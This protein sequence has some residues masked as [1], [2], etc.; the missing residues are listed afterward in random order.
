[1]RGLRG[2]VVGLLPLYSLVPRIQA[3]G[4]VAI[5]DF[6]PGL[7][8]GAAALYLVLPE[9]G[10]APITRLLRIPAQR[11]TAVAAS[12]V[13]LLIVFST[14]VQGGGFTALG[15]TGLRL[16]SY[17]LI[18]AFL[19][20]Q[21]WSVRRTV[22]RLWLAVALAHASCAVFA[23]AWDWHGPLGMGLMQGS[24]RGQGFFSGEAAT[25]EGV[26]NRVN[27]YSAYLL[28]SLGAVP[29]SLKGRWTRGALLVCAVLFAGIV[30]AQTRMTLIALV[31]A[32]LGSLGWWR[33]CRPQ[34]AP[35]ETGRV[36]AGR[37]VLLL[38]LLLGVSGVWLAPT[39]SGM[40]IFSAATDRPLQWRIAGGVIAESPLWGV[41]DRRYLEA[42][43]RLF[44][45]RED[46]QAR[47][48]GGFVVRTP[49][50]SVLY[51]A[52]SYGIPSAVAYLALWL[53]LFVR[54]WRG[55]GA[56]EVE[57]EGAPPSG[58]RQAAQAFVLVAFAL[59]DQTN[60][61]GFVPA[62]ALAGVCIY[63]LSLPQLPLRGS[64][65]ARR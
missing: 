60:N 21:R 31:V 29:L 34:P 5:D 20:C 40:H 15:R 18:G 28:L 63:A 55:R 1:M 54:L 32:G 37:T 13:I 4:P 39:V 16:A 43:G 59:H 24:S 65:R 64:V 50:N 42:A 33:L 41:G 11:H 35:H 53:L 14:L 44:T 46:L 62:V 45:A 26:L 10:E 6:I 2:A 57:A 9:D 23:F 22:L 56:A 17:G 7:V 8:A 27:F 38:A 48:Q 19:V 61:L 30:V 3:F 36:P 49:H 51:V 12:A 58:M 47:Q 52:A 25:G